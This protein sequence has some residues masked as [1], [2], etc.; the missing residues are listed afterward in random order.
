M[1]YYG[2]MLIVIIKSDHFA[3]AR[4]IPAQMNTSHTH[5]FH[6]SRNTTCSAICNG[7]IMIKSA[8]RADI[9][10]ATLYVTVK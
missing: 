7:K 4:S 10:L 5:N 3:I 2:K 9:L 8:Q 1:Q 6:L